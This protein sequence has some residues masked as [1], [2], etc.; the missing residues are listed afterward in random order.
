MVGVLKG[1]YEEW[2]TCHLIYSLSSQYS[3][4]ILYSPLLLLLLLLLLDQKKRSNDQQRKTRKR[5]TLEDYCWLFHQRLP[6]CSLSVVAVYS[7]I[8]QTRIF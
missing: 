8:G 5:L 7:G 6:V 2:L 1:F 3:H 4:E